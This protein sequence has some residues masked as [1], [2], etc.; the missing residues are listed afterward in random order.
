MLRVILKRNPHCESISDIQCKKY[1]K[2]EGSVF[3]PDIIAK[4]L[5]RALCINYLKLFRLWIISR[6]LTKKS[7]KI[8]IYQFFCYLH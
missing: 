3:I 1:V 4:T 7:F 6:L 2:F 5:S 8:N